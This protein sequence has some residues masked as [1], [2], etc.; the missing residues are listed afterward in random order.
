MAAGAPFM[1]FRVIFA[2]VG[3]WLC[4]VAAVGPIGAAAEQQE[5]PAA[6]KPDIDV[7]LLGYYIWAQPSYIELCKKEG[8]NIYTALPNDPTGADP[9]DYPVEYLKRFHVIIVSGPLERP[10]DPCVIQ[11]AIKP[12]IVAN[13]LD[14][15][16]QGGGLVWTPL[17]AGYGANSWTDS[18]GK[19]IDAVALD[20]ALDDSSKDVS[21]SLMSSFR[22]SLR[23]F[24][25]TD[26]S[27]HPATEGVRG[28]FFGRDGEW[29]WP[30]TI[31]MKFGKS[32][33][34]L[35]RGMDSTRTTLNGTP[36]GTGKRQFTFLRKAGTYASSPPLI[37]VRNAVDDGK[38][39][40]MLQPIY[41]TWTWG[42]YRHPA[43]KEAFLLN[44]DGIHPSDGQRF[45]LNAWRWLAEPA[46]AAGHFGGYQPPEKRE[47]DKPVDLSP[48]V[49]Q[50]ADWSS[51]R[52]EP[53]IRG[54]FGAQSKW[55]GGSGT[56]AEWAAAAR[57]A[58]LDYI[59]FTDDPNKH[60]PET[61]AALVAECKKI[62]DDKFAIVPGLGAYD[63]ND[64]YRFFPGAPTL[65][66][67]THFDKQGRMVQPVGITIDYGWQIGQVVTGMGTMPYNPWWE[68]VIMAC[69]PL[70]YEGD[71]LVDDGVMRWLLSCEAHQTNLLPMSLVR[72]KSPDALASAA[73]NAHTTVLRTDKV[74]EIRNFARKGADGQVMPSYLSNGPRLPVWLV[75]GSPGEPFRP[76]SSR[77]RI[78]LRAA[79]DAGLA[80]VK[81]I[82]AADGSIYRLWKPGGQKGFTTAI[83]ERTSDQRVLGLIVTDVNGRTAIAPPVYTFQGANRLWQMSDR[84]MGMHH[85]T[86]WDQQRKHLV[87]YGAPSDI[88]YCKG[89]NEGGGE[90]VS[91][92]V[93]ALKFQGIEG[94]GIYPPAFK[95]VPSLDTDLG[96]VGCGAPTPLALRYAQRLAGHDLTVIDYVGDQQYRQGQQGG[97]SLTP[98]VPHDTTIADIVSR[99][100]KIRTHTLASV[101]MMVNEITVIFKRDVTLNRLYLGHYSGPD[102]AGE[103]N[104]LVIKPGQGQPA[105]S[106]EFDQGEKFSRYT[107]FTPGG[108]LYQAKMLAGTMG[109][110]AMD[111]KIACESQARHHEFLLSKKYLGKYR[112]GDKLTVRMLRVSRAYEAQQG[113]NVWLEQFLHDY[114]I[115]TAPAYSYKLA[116][117]ALRGIN[118]V[119]DLDQ[120]DGGATVEIAKYDLPEPL[121]VRVAGVRKNAMLGEYDLDTK[122]VRPLPYFEGSTTT[123]IETQLKDTR[124]YV[125]EW[126]SWD[127]DAV[128]VSLVS[129]GVDFALEAHNPTSEAVTCTLTGAS[130]FAPFHGLRKELR[131]PPYGSVKEKIKS[132]LGTVALEPIR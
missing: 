16:R 2:S 59:V 121:P 103:F 18:I 17:G 45:L 69:A 71:K 126:L 6:A 88:T 74:S 97:F 117:G 24:W 75:Q 102:A 96:S 114:G 108:Y 28:L 12:G 22:N 47:E 10:W 113:N 87:Q 67:R 98:L 40:M 95:L 21:V 56:V 3:T 72:L 100:W 54:I 89:I 93:A 41:T 116:Q 23:Y 68:H 27:P 63:I 92:H 132:T 82:D 31:P 55:G 25:T 124:L 7:L 38:G 120:Q 123:S 90:F 29:G 64:V 49:W 125:G 20:E 84:L 46:L 42:N 81:I 78:L 86:S 65:P 127:N 70:S 58:G 62:S 104:F 115:A 110:V 9:A 79:S 4:V 60:T 128:R 5:R 66:V 35:V 39:R 99:N 26:I 19:R 73:K 109:F 15:N 36:A 77:F 61:Y 1:R 131:I 43:M 57:A 34:V 76:G 83:D 48:V 14:Y 91:N 51:I 85:T 130:G 30:G 94:C 112:A 101:V 111:D 118:Y 52:S 8:I 106:W 129:D 32:W 11:T 119:M 105:L 33:N 50:D 37:A 122:R 53:T 44:G 80:E 13:L 107:E